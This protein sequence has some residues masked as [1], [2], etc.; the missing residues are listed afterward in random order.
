MNAYTLFRYTLRFVSVLFASEV[1]AFR[2]A[3]R[4][5]HT[6]N[7]SE[8]N[9]KQVHSLL[10]FDAS[11]STFIV[12]ARW[13]CTTRKWLICQD[14]GRVSLL[15]RWLSSAF[16]HEAML[17]EFYNGL[18]A[19]SSHLKPFSSCSWI[20]L[21]KYQKNVTLNINFKCK[22]IMDQNS[23]RQLTWF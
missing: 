7:I 10:Y 18:W 6:K 23:K 2:G 5:T 22:L 21:R 12:S 1:I 19:N 15:T 14:S 11:C 17:V 13:L 9:L 8:F 4:H 16:T 3:F 20:Y